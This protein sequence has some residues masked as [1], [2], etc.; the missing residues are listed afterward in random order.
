MTVAPTHQFAIAAAITMPGAVAHNL[1]MVQGPVRGPVA[2]VQGERQVLIGNGDTRTQF[3]PSDPRQAAAM[4]ALAGVLATTKAFE[5]A[6][7]APDL[8]TTL[9]NSPNAKADVVTLKD[10]EG[11]IS[12]MRSDGKFA[13]YRGPLSG[14]EAPAG[15]QDVIAAVRA[16]DSAMAP[17]RTTK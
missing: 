7:N 15:I 2:D 5:V 4:D 17:A 8:I 1:L 9:I 3:N 14:P 12:A 10:G 13:S 16:L 11:W 6:P